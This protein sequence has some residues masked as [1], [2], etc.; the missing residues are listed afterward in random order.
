MSK[1]DRE[2][3]WCWCLEA[4]LSTSRPVS[5]VVTE[6]PTHPAEIPGEIA[7]LISVRHLS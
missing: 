5:D 1:N 7:T 3:L 4:D 2:S 6:N